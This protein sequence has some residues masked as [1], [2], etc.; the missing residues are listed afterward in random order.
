[1]SQGNDAVKIVE[2]ALELGFSLPEAIQ[3]ALGRTLSDWAAERGF[4]RSEV[5]MCF[6]GYKGRIQP[7]VRN[8]AA[9]DL[10]VSRATVDAWIERAARERA[11]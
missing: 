1:M 5:S 8:A 6:L 7:K 10:G 11:A 2:G 4:H 3:R 9:E